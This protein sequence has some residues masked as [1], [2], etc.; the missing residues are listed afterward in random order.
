MNKQKFQFFKDTVLFAGLQVS[1]TSVMP[2]TKL[3]ESL[4]NFPVPK[5]ITGAH[6]RFGLVNQGS[7]VFA[8]TEEIA[9]FR[10][11]LKPKTKFEW[12]EELD[13]AFKLSKEN[14]TNKIKT[15]VE[16]FDIN[17]LTC[18]ATDFSGIGVANI[19]C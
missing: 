7:Y 19:L 18:L 6:T 8:M 1:R 2:S 5:V 14:I 15:G 13:K 10:H 3:L 9:P 12:T 11:L 17:L 16:L 4:R